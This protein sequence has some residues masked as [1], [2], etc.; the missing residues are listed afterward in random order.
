L[1]TSS[2]TLDAPDTDFGPLGLNLLYA[3][4]DPV[5]ELI[6]VHGLRGG[7]RKTWSKTSS[8]H[9]FWPKEWLPRDPEFENTRIFSFG[10]DS[11]WGARKGSVLNV[12]DFGKSLLSE[13]LNSPEIRR[14]GDT[15]IIFIGHSMGGLVIKKAYVLANQDPASK[16]LADRVHGLFFLATP[17]RGADS[18]TML[19]NVLRASAYGSKAFVLDLERNSE[20]LQTIND[21]FR[22]YSNALEL[23]SFYETI[24]TNLGMSSQLIVNPDSAVLGYHNEESALLNANHRNICKFDTLLDSNFITFRNSLASMTRSVT[25]GGMLAMYR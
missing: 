21:E 15:P 25:Q 12:H 2:Q 13:L 8:P 1:T 22:H 5:L 19:K 10:Y 9:H 4:P 18:A 3:A 6:F 11:N 14:D 7:S 24:K 16:S 20:A 23:R 17:H